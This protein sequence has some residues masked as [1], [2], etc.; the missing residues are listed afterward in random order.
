MHIKN[1]IVFNDH[2]VLLFIDGNLDLE[3][4]GKKKKKK[5]K[6]FNMQELDGA[7]PDQG[8]KSKDEGTMEVDGTQDESLVEVIFL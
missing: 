7:L 3:N 6:P 5:K 1:K 4:F 8:S 2:I